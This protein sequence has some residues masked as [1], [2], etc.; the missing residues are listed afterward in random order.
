M[1]AVVRSAGYKRRNQEVFI[2]PGDWG[3]AQ[4]SLGSYSVGGLSRGL[5]QGNA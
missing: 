3:S 4:L 5:A 1:G 2:P